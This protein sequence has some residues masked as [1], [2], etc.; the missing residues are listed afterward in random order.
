[1]IRVPII[2]YVNPK[3]G[4]FLMKIN[5]IIRQ[6]RVEKGLT[7]EQVAKYLGVSTPAVSKWESGITYPDIVLLPALARLLE[8]DLNT[9][10]SFQDSLS[11]EEVIQFM[12]Q[13]SNTIANEG[14]EHGYQLAM[15]KIKEFPNSD[16]LI[17]NIAMLLNGGLMWTNK[18]RNNM[19]SEQIELLL[20][21]ASNSADLNIKEQSQSILVSKLI[22]N[23]KFDEAQKILDTFRKET[24]ADQKKL[25]ADL[26]IAE[27]EL[28]KGA[29]IM[30]EKLMSSISQI[31]SYLMILMEIALK[32]ERILDANY[33]ADVYKQMSTLFD[34]WEYNSYVAHYQ[35]YDATKNRKESM[36]LLKPM[37]KSLTTQWNI[38][39]SPL[40]RH[41]KAKKLDPRFGKKLQKTLFQALNTKD[42]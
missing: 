18:E 27:G 20:K 34:L 31:Q 28:S 26:Y 42:S 12:N 32:E 7:Q 10:L 13:V 8:T 6:K 36:K 37:L 3:K 41:I 5:E 38:N 24:W 29:Q 14:F 2:I 17:G 16:F 22:E 1:M 21:R 30:E 23:G 39:S 40:Y 15:D 11:E 9:L 19:Y 33:I 25:Q 4:V 35:L